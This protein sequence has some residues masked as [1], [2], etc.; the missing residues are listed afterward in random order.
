VRAGTGS[1]KYQGFFQLAPPNVGGMQNIQAGK[2]LLVY[3]GIFA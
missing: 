2:K 1:H 3:L